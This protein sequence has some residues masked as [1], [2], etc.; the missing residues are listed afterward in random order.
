MHCICVSTNAGNPGSLLIVEP[1]SPT[2]LITKSKSRMLSILKRFL[3]EASV[4][5]VFASTY[6]QNA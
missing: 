6:E 1:G 2:R 3:L 5:Y 4:L